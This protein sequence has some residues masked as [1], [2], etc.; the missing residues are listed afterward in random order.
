VLLVALV[1]CGVPCAWLHHLGAEQ[2]KAWTHLHLRSLATAVEAYAA[3]E[4]NKTHELPSSL[5]DLV[6]PPFGGTS[7]LRHGERELI[8][9]WG[10][11]FQYER[12]LTAGGKES[13]LIWTTTPGGTPIS[14][15]GI[16]AKEA[17]P[18]K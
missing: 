4:S 8:D 9:L 17:F 13:V 5:N 11:P 16:G 12:R 10:K 1:F 7:F 18:E 3:C 6:N 2:R 15:Y 14:Q